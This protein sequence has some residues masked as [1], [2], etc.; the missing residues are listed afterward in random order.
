MSLFFTWRTGAAARAL[1]LSRS[2]LLPIQ[3]FQ[4]LTP[5]LVAEGC[6]S[7]QLTLLEEMLRLHKLIESESI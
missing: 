6:F 3:A 2:A 5:H 7:G 1:A 4:Q